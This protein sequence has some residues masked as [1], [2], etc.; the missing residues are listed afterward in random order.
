MGNTVLDL[1]FRLLEVLAPRLP[2]LAL[3]RFICVSGIWRPKSY[4][5][6][7][8]KILANL[9]PYFPTSKD[10]IYAQMLKLE[11]RMVAENALLARFPE[12]TREAFKGS[13]PLLPRPC[14]VVSGHFF[15]FWLLIELLRVTGN[16]TVFVMGQKPQPGSPAE[17]SGWRAWR[18]WRKVQEFIYASEGRSYEK[19]QQALAEGKRLLL[20]LDTPKPY[21]FSAHLLGRKISVAAGGLKLGRKMNLPV[22][23][24][25]PVPVHPHQPYTLK[26]KELPEAPAP[27]ILAA[28]MSLAEKLI[29]SYPFSWTGWLY[30]DELSVNDKQGWK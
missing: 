3:Y 16:E 29:T 15:N 8:K 28:F 22:W 12:K 18:R 14:L 7:R 27:E 30:L 19:C 9:A 6:L 24:I 10:R 23:F 17:K 20:L 21:G 5:S 25:L 2:L 26:I 4:A 11:A 13:L 1:Y